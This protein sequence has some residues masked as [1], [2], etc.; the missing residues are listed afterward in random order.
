MALTGQISTDPGLDGRRAARTDVVLGAGLRQ[1]GAHA[2]T[3]QIMDLSTH[4]FRAA[5]HLELEPGAD[6]WLKM[7]GLESMHARVAWMRGH[8]MGCEF[9]RPLHPAVLDMVVRAARN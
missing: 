7:P 3:V 5:T 1:R 4:G 6:V 2:V 9:V 8:L